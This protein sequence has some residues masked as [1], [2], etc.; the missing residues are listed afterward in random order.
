MSGS[1]EA[2][3]D[4]AAVG[5]EAG[6]GWKGATA[7]DAGAGTTGIEGGVGWGRKEEKMTLREV[8][9]WRKEEL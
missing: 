3:L 4:G 9:T 5:A 7:G 6:G 8:R 1:A 2:G